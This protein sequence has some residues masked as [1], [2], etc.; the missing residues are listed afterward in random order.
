MKSQKS[1]KVVTSFFFSSPDI[2]K[3]RCTFSKLTADVKLDSSI[4][5]S[6]VFILE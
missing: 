3:G 5:N 2:Q 6:I 1:I 4:L